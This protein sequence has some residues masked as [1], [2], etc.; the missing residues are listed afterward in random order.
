MQIK[1]NGFQVSEMIGRGIE[2]TRLR[3]QIMRLWV[4]N[5]CCAQHTSISVK[6]NQDNDCPGLALR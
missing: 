3:D 5:L 1:G 4:V 6:Q 2:T